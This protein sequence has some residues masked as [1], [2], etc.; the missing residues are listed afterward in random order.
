VTLLQ[1]AAVFLVFDIL[2]VPY[3]FTKTKQITN[4]RNNGISIR[5]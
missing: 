3:L 5:R 4:A 2:L 1:I